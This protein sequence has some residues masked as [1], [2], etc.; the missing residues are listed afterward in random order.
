MG[1][2]AHGDAKMRKKI[3]D[4]ALRAMSPEA[5]ELALSTLIAATRERPNGELVE[6]SAAIEELE[7]RNSLDSA[8]MRAKVEAG[9][10]AESWEICQWLILLDRRERLEKLAS[11][12]C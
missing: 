10:L 7:A 6:L 9:T 5:R 8:T 1:S 4:T 12:P 11:R 2:G 3:S